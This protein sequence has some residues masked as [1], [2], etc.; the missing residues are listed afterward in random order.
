MPKKK[1]DARRP[2]K[3]VKINKG[4]PKFKEVLTEIIKKKVDV[5]EK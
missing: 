4:E 1:E 2:K 5:P 3:D